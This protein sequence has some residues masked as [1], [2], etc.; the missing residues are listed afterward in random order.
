MLAEV[1]KVLYIN[2]A[3]S[4]IQLYTDSRKIQIA[5]AVTYNYIKIREKH[6]IYI[7][8]LHLLYQ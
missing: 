7:S 6:K 3:D 5:K 8:N 4:Y 1:K 2:I